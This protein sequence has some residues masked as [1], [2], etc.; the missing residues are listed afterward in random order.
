MKHNFFQESLC[1]NRY[2]HRFEI[3]EEYEDGV[4]E[5][6]EICHIRK[7]F[8]IIDGKVDNQRYMSYHIRQA[9]PTFHEYYEHERFYE[10][11]S[12]VSPYI[13]NV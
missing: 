6:C 9:L 11:L 8:K 4:L 3:K 7:F 1:Q 12:I 2:L 13:V 10:P 5:V